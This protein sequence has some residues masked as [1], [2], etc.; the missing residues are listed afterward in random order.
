MLGI[1]REEQVEVV[2]PVAV[3]P[4]VGPLRDQSPLGTC[5]EIDGLRVHH[6]AFYYVPAV[7]KRYDGY[8]YGRSLLGWVRRHC[9][10]RRPD[11]IDAHFAWPDGVGAAYMAG[12]LGLPF[13]ITLRGTINPRYPIA[14][15]RKRL[16]GALRRAD[17]VISVSGPMAEIAIELGVSPRRVFVIPNGVDEEQY[18]PMSREAARKELGLRIDGRLI[19]CVAS[20]KQAK[21]IEDLLVAFAKM[22][23]DAGLILVGSA[24]QGDSYVGKL[25]SLAAGLGVGG[26]VSFAGS[27]PPESVAKHFNAADVSVLASHNE[28]CPNVVIESLACGT[29]VVASDVGAVGEFVK[30]GRSGLLVTP[31]D[32]EGL[33]KAMGSALAREW[34]REEIRRSVEGRSWRQVAGRVLEVFDEVVGRRRARGRVEEEA[35]AAEAQRR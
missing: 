24:P 12:K 16:A 9:A 21:G 1:A 19:V 20:L 4:L 11:L 13:T 14:C 29:P 34:S 6:R 8:F 33:A 15:F 18:K 28:G 27:Q 26:R 3:C 31:R 22:P 23:A 32:R 25:K 35:S 5:E 30:D 7:L 10:W 2:H 17:A